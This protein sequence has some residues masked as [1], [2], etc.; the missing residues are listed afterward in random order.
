M[1]CGT[2]GNKIHGVCLGDENAEAALV[3]EY[4]TKKAV[5][6]HPAQLRV[7]WMSKASS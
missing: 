2:T 7:L 5:F 1:K 3:P 6:P 4:D